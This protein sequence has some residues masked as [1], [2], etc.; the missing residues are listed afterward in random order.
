MEAASWNVGYPIFGAR[1]L[2]EDTLL[3]AGG[4]GEGNHG[5][6]N[7]LT[8]LQ[9][10]FSRKNKVIKK[11]RE[12][13]LPPNSDSPMSLDTN[14]EIILMGCNEGSE[15]I[16]KGK[17]CHLRKYDYIDQHLVFSKSI[18][19]FTDFSN[20]INNYTKCCYISDDSSI[21]CISNS[22]E[23]NPQLIIINTSNN[24]LKL[25]YKII[26]KTNNIIKDLHISPDGKTI[27][28]I[29]SSTF[30]AISTVSGKILISKNSSA[31][32]TSSQTLIFAKIRFINNNEF[33]IGCNI[34][35]KG[36]ISIVHY[37]ILDQLLISN[38]LISKKIKS[39]TSMDFWPNIIIKVYQDIKNPEKTITKSEID[40]N[41]SLI[42]IA[43]NNYSVILLK[44]KNFKNL[45]EFKKTHNF[46][47]TKVTFSPTGQYLASVSAANTIHV[48]KLP[49]KFIT[50]NQTQIKSKNLNTF[51]SIILS[52]LF[53]LILAILIQY[54]I[55]KK[56]I[57]HLIDIPTIKSEL[58][59]RR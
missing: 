20:D 8:A 19:L 43:G 42:S 15:K 44:F 40:I 53:V 17:N 12:L 14:G 31:L 2:D 5:I 32:S 16:K 38:K 51:L 46:V 6:P 57:Q 7:K 54:L 50:S 24:Q 33:I 55:N 28:Y 48:I 58:K 45:F 21:G 52:L 22:N 13:Q 25:K 47:I 3:V 11:F 4:G 36:G 30:K 41:N 37:S 59:K 18:N 49:S 35:N 26:E 1:F 39:I 34:N 27:V 29:T 9:I 10:D 56:L 23:K